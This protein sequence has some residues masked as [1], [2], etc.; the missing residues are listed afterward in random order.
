MSEGLQRF[1]DAQKD[2]YET[3][4]A[5][6]KDGRRDQKTL[7]ILKND[8]APEELTDREVYNTPIGPVCMSRTEYEAYVEERALRKK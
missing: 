5:E 4:L 6:V 7:E 8:E 3:A 2:D 1:R